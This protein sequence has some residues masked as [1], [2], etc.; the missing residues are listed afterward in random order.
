MG[1][2]MSDLTP[3]AIQKAISR[4]EQVC[5]CKWKIRGTNKTITLIEALLLGMTSTTN[6]FGERLFADDMMDIWKDVCTG[7]VPSSVQVC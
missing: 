6:A 4:E 3:A 7:M 2:G 5:H 1:T